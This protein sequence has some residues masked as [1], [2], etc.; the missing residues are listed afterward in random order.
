[1]TINHE[2][3]KLIFYKVVKSEDNTSCMVTN[4]LLQLT[5]EQGDIITAHKAS[6]GIL[7]FRI[8]EQAHVFVEQYWPSP[9]YLRTDDGQLHQRK[10]AKVKRIESLGQVSPPGK[11]I[12]VHLIN[13][14]EDNSDKRIHFSTVEDLMHYVLC[15]SGKY[16]IDTWPH[17][18]ICLEKCRVLD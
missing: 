6:I 15:K 9:L 3:G 2:T 11:G 4:P 12:G 8:L 14:P 7:A 17:G 16:P 10:E 5:Y 18:T 1:M 13:C